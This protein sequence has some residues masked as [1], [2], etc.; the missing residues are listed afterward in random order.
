MMLVMKM[1]ESSLDRERQ[2][3]PTCEGDCELAMQ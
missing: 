2:E 1:P 3:A